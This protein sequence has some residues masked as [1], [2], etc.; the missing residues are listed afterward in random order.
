MET[1]NKL[2]EVCHHG[3]LKRQ[4]EMCQVIVER[5]ALKAEL[6]KVN[7]SQP[8]S[9]WIKDRDAWRTLALAAKEALEV[10]ENNIGLIQ[11]GSSQ[12][13]W[14]KIVEKALTAFPPTEE[15]YNRH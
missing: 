13:R 11:D 14:R 5:D 15:K 8:T 10:C 4:C 9:D 6:E 7:L 1:V 3:S 12:Q 2:G